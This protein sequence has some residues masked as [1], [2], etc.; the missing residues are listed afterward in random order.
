MSHAVEAVTETTA[1]E[2]AKGIVY[3]EEEMPNDEADFDQMMADAAK[4]AA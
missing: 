1:E 3:G 4:E 2:E